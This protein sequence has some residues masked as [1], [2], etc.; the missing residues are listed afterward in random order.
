VKEKTAPEDPWAAL[1]DPA[2][3]ETRV[4]ELFHE[5]SKVSRWDAPISSEHVLRRMGEMH[6]TFPYDAYPATRLPEPSA[7]MPLSVR[8]AI[9]ARRTARVLEPVPV[10]LETLSSLLSLAYGVTARN[11]GTGF[12]RPFRAVP[13]GGALYPLEL[14]FHAI[15]VEGIAPGLY[16]YNPLRHEVRRLREGDFSREIAAALVQRDAAYDSSL[17]LFITAFFER[18]AFKYGERAYRFAL[19]EAGHVAQNVALAA[20][21]L[22]LGTRCIGGFFDRAVDAFLDLD[23]CTQSALYLVALGRIADDGVHGPNLPE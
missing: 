3:G 4:W 16:H 7:E 5:N 13:S 6:E 17:L 9:L 19:L 10:A 1:R 11:E 21:A 8:D 12:T 22:G 20:T 15:H 14:F 18:S 23:G 2:A